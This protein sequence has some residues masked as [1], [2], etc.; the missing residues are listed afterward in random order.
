MS[1]FFPNPT[2]LCPQDMRG[3]V[4]SN[5]TGHLLVGGSSFLAISQPLDARL[6]AVRLLNLANAM[7]TAQQE[8]GEA[9]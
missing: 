9:A 5:G 8:T 4:N 1:A 6:I 3:V 7:E 2:A